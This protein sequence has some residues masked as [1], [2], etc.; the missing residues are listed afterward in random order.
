MSR[1]SNFTKPLSA[2][3]LDAR[4]HAAC[5]QPHLLRLVDQLGQ[6]HDPDLKHLRQ[7]AIEISTAIRDLD[8][9]LAAISDDAN[10]A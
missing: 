3:L 4:I 1:P 9:E 2:I 8:D 6:L 5:V 7:Q 10:A